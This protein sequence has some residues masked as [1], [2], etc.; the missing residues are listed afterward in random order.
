MQVAYKFASDQIVMN[1][2]KQNHF[3]LPCVV[4][5]IFFPFFRIG[6]DFP[7]IQMSQ[8]DVLVHL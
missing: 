6:F 3:V 1:V 5:S 7:C 8:K 2:G 4:V